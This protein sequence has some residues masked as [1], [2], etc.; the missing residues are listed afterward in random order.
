MIEGKGRL[1]VG[2]GDD[3]WMLFYTSEDRE[4][5]NSVG[6]RHADGSVVYF[7]GDHTLLS[8]KYFVPKDKALSVIETWF[9]TGE[10]NR[11]V[12]WTTELFEP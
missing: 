8:R 12:N 11:A 3:E 4:V 6:N 10:L 2:L 7:F 5:L 9:H 1:S